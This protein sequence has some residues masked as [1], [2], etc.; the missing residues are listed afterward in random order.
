VSTREYFLKR[1]GNPGTTRGLRETALGL[2]VL[3][4]EFV[5]G[6]DLRRLCG[7]QY[8][9][10]QKYARHYL[11]PA[12]GTAY[13]NMLLD[14]YVDCLRAMANAAKQAFLDDFRENGGPAL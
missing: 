3:L 12:D 5:L 7:E 4:S 10:A 8:R 6:D 13:Q 14:A 2:E 9:E 11:K 1:Y